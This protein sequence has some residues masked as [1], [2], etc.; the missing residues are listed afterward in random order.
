MDDEGIEVDGSRTEETIF[1][2]LAELC[3]FPGFVHVI[4][5]VC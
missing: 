2:E 4:A 1:G 3:A 5:Y